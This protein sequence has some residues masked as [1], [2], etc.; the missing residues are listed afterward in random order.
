MTILIIAGGVRLAQSLIMQSIKTLTFK[1]LLKK[2][3]DITKNN[4]HS[5]LLV[6]QIHD[7]FLTN[8]TTR[9]P[10]ATPLTWATIY[11]INQLYVV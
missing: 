4:L 10:G 11:I 6:L 2:S 3:I 9:V 5:F 7:L 1:C 8:V